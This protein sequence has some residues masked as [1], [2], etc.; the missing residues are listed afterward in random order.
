MAA[1]AHLD[2]IGPP[3]FAVTL[4]AKDE[5]APVLLDLAVP[6]EDIDPL[7]A[8]RPDRER[9]PELWWLLERGAHALVRQ[10]GTVGS[11]PDFPPLLERL[12]PVHRYFWVYVFLATLPQVRA[13]HQGRGISAEVSRRTLADLGRNMAVH[14][15][16]YGEGGLGVVFWIIRHFTGAIYDLGRLQFERVTLGNRSGQAVRAAGFPHTTGDP[17]LSVHIPEFSGPMSPTACDA[18]FARARTFFPKHFPEE[19]Y[20]LAVCWSWLMDEQLAEYLPASSNIVQFQRRFTIAAREEVDDAGIV[21]FVFG[22]AGWSPDQLDDLPQRTTLER[23]IVD[24]LRAGRHWYGG[25][26]WMEL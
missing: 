26:G 5:L 23:A 2:A 9:S 6:H 4:P 20:R 14:R 24:H 25:T 13:F 8:L 21:R 16:W 17:V 22:R 1:L 3:P 19:T 18:A 15:R 10:I 7:I 12:G 11:L